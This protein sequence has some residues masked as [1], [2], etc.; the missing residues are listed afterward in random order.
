LR[1]PVQMARRVM[2]VTD[3][4]NHRRELSR[5]LRHSSTALR[6]LTSVLGSVEEVAPVLRV[7]RFTTLPSRTTP[8]VAQ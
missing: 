8:Y 7:P 3:V 2:G 5:A 6:R 4:S 1:L